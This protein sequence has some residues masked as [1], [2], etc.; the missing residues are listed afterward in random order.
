[1]LEIDLDEYE[2]DRRIYPRY[3][4]KKEITGEQFD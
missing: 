2:G 3:G 4:A 1:V